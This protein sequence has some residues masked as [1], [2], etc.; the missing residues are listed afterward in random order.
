[1][2]QG[3]RLKTPQKIDFSIGKFAFAFEEANPLL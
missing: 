2:L 3:Y 1:V